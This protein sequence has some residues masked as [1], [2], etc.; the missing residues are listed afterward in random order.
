MEF[1]VQRMIYFVMHLEY[2]LRKWTYFIKVLLLKSSLQL[3]E[4]FLF[5]KSFWCTKKLPLLLKTGKA[6]DSQG[7]CLNRLG[8]LLKPFFML[9]ETCSNTRILT[10]LTTKAASRRPFKRFIPTR[11][12]GTKLVVWK[13]K[14]TDYTDWGQLYNQQI[15]I[16]MFSLDSF[17]LNLVKG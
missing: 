16:W 14:L 1:G 2:S 9:E 7:T 11:N 5:Q 6:K 17:R 15:Y 12:L 13:C 3:H 8:K 4:Y 10:F